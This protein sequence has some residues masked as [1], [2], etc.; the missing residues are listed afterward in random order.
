M[1][2]LMK[3]GMYIIASVAASVSIASGVSPSDVV[4]KFAS[5]GY[6]GPYAGTR[7]VTEAHLICLRQTSRGEDAYAAS[8]E[9]GF[10]G[11]AQS[12]YKSCMADYVPFKLAGADSPNACASEAVSWGQC[13]ATVPSLV[14]GAS[15]TVSND[16]NIDLSEGKSPF[17]GFAV[18]QCEGGQVKFQ[19]GGCARTA[20][21]CE[22]GLVVDWSVTSPAWA[23]ESTKTEYIDLYGDTR[24]VPKGRCKSLMSEASSGSAVMA[25]VTDLIMTDSGLALENYADT[26]AAPQR[27]FDGEWLPDSDNGE[28]VC[29]YVPKTCSA[30]VKT[31]NGC[32]FELPAGEHNTIH[33][34]TTPAPTNSIGTLEAY[35]FDGEWEV[36]AAACQKSCSSSIPA[37]EWSGEDTRACGHDVFSFAERQA[38]NTAQLVNNSVEGMTGTSTKTC[39]DGTWVTSDTTDLCVPQ[40]CDYIPAKTWSSTDVGSERSCAHGPITGAQVLHNESIHI[41]SEGGNVSGAMGTVTYRCEYGELQEALTEDGY[42]SATCVDISVQC[43]SQKVVSGESAPDPTD[44]NVPIPGN[45]QEFDLCQRKGVMHRNGMCCYNNTTN[46]ITSCYEIP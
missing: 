39:N 12:E 36:K 41:S 22:D 24:H 15:A 18:F 4:G 1:K 21:K 43:Y 7:T 46:K 37:Y 44:P 14:E 30:E 6:V 33:I 40:N 19:S 32:D 20:T 25:T 23:D 8:G 31:F 26:N 28:S 29:E 45:N 10:S 2:S 35:C 13:T 11:D 9:N 27:C 38:P 17:E 3:W 42:V 16:S 5:E 34:N